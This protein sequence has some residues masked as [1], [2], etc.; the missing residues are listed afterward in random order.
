MSPKSKSVEDI[1]GIDI[2]R[3]VIYEFNI[4]IEQAKFVGKVF[5]RGRE[6]ITQVL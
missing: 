4:K 6:L 5:Q 2:L 3:I 1:I